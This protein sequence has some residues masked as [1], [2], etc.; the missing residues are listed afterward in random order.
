MLSTLYDSAVLIAKDYGF[1][2]E[3]RQAILDRLEEAA[4]KGEF[5]VRDP[6]TGLP[7]RPRHKEM[8]YYLWD[9]VSADD[10]NA[11]LQ[12]NGVEYRL[13]S[14]EQ[15]QQ[16]NNAPEPERVKNVDEIPGK[17]PLREV[18]KLAIK[19]AWQI[20]CETKRRASAKE[21]MTRL[22]GW[23]DAGNESDTLM[24]SLPAKRAVQWLTTK[25]AHREYTTEACQE[26]LQRWNESRQ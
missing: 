12:K 13:D 10:L 26:A 20:E 3:T 11:W 5:V 17:P 14:P 2:I 8:F 22:Q 6:L 16:G 9:I 23:A 4:H 24:K 21:V 19:A 25:G 18:G 15:E 1:D 7:Y